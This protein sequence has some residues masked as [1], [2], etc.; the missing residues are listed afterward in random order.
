MSGRVLDRVEELGIATANRSGL[1]I[2]A[3]A[4]RDP[5]EIEEVGAELFERGVF[6]T[7]AVHPL[8]PHDEIGFRLQLTAAHSDEQV[9]QLCAVLEQVAGRFK[10]RP[11]G[12]AVRG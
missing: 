1:P 4:L 8:V 10:M 2:I 6:A 3:L 12:A 7:T 11:P 5:A 9:D